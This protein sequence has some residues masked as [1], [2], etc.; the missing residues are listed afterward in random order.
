VPETPSTLAMTT[1]I[2]LTRSL[3][4]STLLG[5]ITRPSP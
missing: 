5:A 4:R 2:I 1:P 3:S